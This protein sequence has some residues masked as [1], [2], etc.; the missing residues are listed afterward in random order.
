[1]VFLCK[2]LVGKGLKKIKF[3]LR[4]RLPEQKKGLSLHSLFEREA[5]VPKNLLK[6]DKKFLA[7][8][9]KDIIFAVLLRREGKTRRKGLK[10]YERKFIDIMKHK[11]LVVIIQ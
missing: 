10:R 9:K 7:E 11:Y 5:D 4:K 6:K 1:M 3:F 8:R 2:S